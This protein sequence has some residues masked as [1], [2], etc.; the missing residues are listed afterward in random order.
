M[1]HADPTGLLDLGF[2][3][4]SAGM[5][6]AILHLDW[7]KEATHALNLLRP[8]LSLCLSSSFPTAIYWG[9]DL[10]L[11]Y[12]DAWSPILAD[13]HPW[14]L[15]HPAREVWADI[16]PIVGPQMLQV[17][18]TGKPFSV[19]DQMLPM[20]RHGRR[21]ET[22]WNYSFTPILAEDGSVAGIFN[23]GHEITNRVL[24]E[25]RQQLRLALDEVRHTRPDPTEFISEASALLGHHLAVERVGYAEMDETDTFAVIHRDWTDG[26][27]PS[28]SGALRLDSFGADLARA[29][30]SGETIR[31]DDALDDPLTRGDGTEQA[32]AAVG[33]R[34]TIDVP[35]IR[36][37][38]LTAILFVHAK[39]IRAWA[40]H[41][42]TFTQEV[43][44]RIWEAVERNRGHAMLRESEERYRLLL[45]A[46][47]RQT[48]ELQ[49]VLESMPDG[50]YIG[51]AQ[52]I[53]I[54]N[55]PALD[56]LGFATREELNRDVGTL[57]DEIDTRDATTGE[58]IAVADQAF[59]RAL[60]GERV[61][62]DVIVRHRISGE[63]RIVRSAAAPVKIDGQVIAAVAVN[64][65]V[66]ERR[67]AEANLRLLNETLEA[68]V[69]EALAER[70]L[71][72]T[73]FETSD[74][75]INA[76]DHDY[77]FLA[78][79]RAYV[80]AFERHTG[81]RPVVGASL[82]DY[83]PEDA[84]QRSALARWSR[85]LSGEDVAI[86]EPLAPTDPGS[87]HY[88]LRLNP[89]RDKDGQVVG[90]FQYAIDVTQRLR[91]AARL[92]DAE[93]ALRQ[94][95]KL[96]AMGQLTGGVAHDFNNLLTPIIGSLDLLQRR[97][98]G[99]D[100]AQRQISAA[101][102]SAERA[103]VLVQRLLAFARR[104]PLQPAPVD[105][106]AIVE[107][108]A[109]LIASTSGPRIRIEVD[110][111]AG[112]PPALAD[113]NQIE[114][115]IL[116]LAVNSRDAMPDGGRLGITAKYAE[117]EPDHATRLAA[118]RYIQLGVS[119]TGTGMDE[120]TRLRA[121][122]PFFST[123]GIGK[124]TG[125]GLSMV[126]GL[127]SQLGGALTIKSRPGLGTR[128]DLWLP[129][130]TALPAA[131]SQADHPT[132]E[133]SSGTILLV[134]DEFIVRASTADMLE[135][136][137]YA[138]IEADC[139]E[140]ALA[141]VTEGLRPAMLLTDH[142]MPGMSGTDL[143]ERIRAIL[144]SL[145]VLIVSGYAE[146]EGLPATL[147]RLVKPFRQAELGASL[148]SL[149]APT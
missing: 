61:V 38:R 50:V 72:V 44:A 91:D 145:P 85:A 55:Q 131:P 82:L 68:R 124:G 129:V 31:I 43:A 49:A 130:A 48:A 89:L 132:N 74:A 21:E 60:G 73:I 2:L 10:R 57:A 146:E 19:F 52:G 149:L 109:E 108:M 120:A 93:E 83:L 16:W 30:R 12:N 99:D 77:R 67:R 7:S 123:K 9:A 144:P 15:G 56:Q 107:G 4:A 84:T 79:N 53:T 66:T 34:A 115:A 11:L 46:S 97:R 114:M 126:H 40:D 148:A 105:I 133:T 142:L 113:A 106:A 62:R 75:L 138:V 65:D 118:G 78:F 13:R 134:D 96:E 22:W 110:V 95:Q 18:E 29:L 86:V 71:W 90:A 1:R 8:A 94:S 64:T 100:K 102:Q 88:E 36:H 27:V 112:L 32:F 20:M 28:L 136:L 119:D 141:L 5:A 92:A 81:Q 137:G 3:P 63:E 25:K 33:V 143:A 37:G 104:Q 101:L 26:T 140:E 116:N 23:Q 125:L 69:D 42:V 45:D 127:A 98:V 14:A 51:G 41:E 128:I 6:D 87:R 76:L 111:D 17:V 54:A 35:L 70:R 135:D 147:P 139:A 58:L 39:E 47:Q 59:T 117:I 122:D 103:K 80:E 121:V 24:E